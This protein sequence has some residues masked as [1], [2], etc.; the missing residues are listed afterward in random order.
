MTVDLWSH[1][2]AKLSFN[3]SEA[4]PRLPNMQLLAGLIF[5]PVCLYYYGAV[6]QEQKAIGEQRGKQD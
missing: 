5:W 2:V 1:R 6:K 4:C 3:G